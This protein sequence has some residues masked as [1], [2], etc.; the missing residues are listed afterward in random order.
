MGGQPI[1]SFRKVNKWFGSLHVLRDITL[2]IYEGEV[3][4]IFGPSG[5]GRA[6]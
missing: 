3:V 2:D 5:G 6:R 1:I 4:V